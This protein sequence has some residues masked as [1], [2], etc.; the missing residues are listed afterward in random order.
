MA[1]PYCLLDADLLV[2]S[3]AAN[4]VRRRL[5]ARVHPDHARATATDRTQ[6]RYGHAQEG[7]RSPR[8]HRQYRDRRALTGLRT[9]AF[10]RMDR[11]SVREFDLSVC[12]QRAAVVHDLQPGPR[13]HGER[14]SACYRR[15]QTRHPP[16]NV[17]SSGA[18]RRARSRAWNASA[19]SVVPSLSIRP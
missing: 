10:C 3:R 19:P 5:P 6:V 1:T 14:I 13:E 12:P 9:N 15:S 8:D 2:V 18:C 17:S 7:E 4:R 16:R 11:T